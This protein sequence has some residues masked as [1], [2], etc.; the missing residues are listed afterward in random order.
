MMHDEFPCIYCRDDH[1]CCNQSPAVHMG[2]NTNAWRLRRKR[3]KEASPFDNIRNSKLSNWQY[4]ALP[5][6]CGGRVPP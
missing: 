3:F 5:G 1:R 2:A 6:Y 4:C